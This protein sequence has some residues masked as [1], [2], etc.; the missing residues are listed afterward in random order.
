MGFN[1]G[2]MGF[3][4]GLMGFNHGLMGF[5]GIYPLVS[6]NMVGWKIPRTEWRFLARKITDKW[7]IVQHAMFDC[8]MVY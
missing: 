1:G 3:N 5:Y 2:L 4:D 7:S 8:R 6:S